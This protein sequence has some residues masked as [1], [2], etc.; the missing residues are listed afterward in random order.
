MHHNAHVCDALQGA[1]P[2]ERIFF[3]ADG[4]SQPDPETPNRVS[5]PFYIGEVFLK[6]ASNSCTQ[7]PLEA[8]GRVFRLV[9]IMT[10]MLC[11]A[12]PIGV[13]ALILYPLIGTGCMQIDKKKIWQELQPLLK[14][15][16][17]KTAVFQGEHIMMTSAGPVTTDSLTGANIS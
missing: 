3:G 13:H 12:Y 16:D 5:C 8:V 4:G 14:T 7:V 9:T 2:G 17:S 6:H 11:A 1:S 15:D 10:W